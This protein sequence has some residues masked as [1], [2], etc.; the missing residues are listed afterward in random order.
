MQSEIKESL[1]RHQIQGRSKHCANGETVL[2]INTQS[3]VNS[4]ERLFHASSPVWYIQTSA[5]KSADCP[6]C[7]A[8]R[9][10]T[11]PSFLFPLSQSVQP[12]QLPFQGLKSCS[13]L[14]TLKKPAQITSCA[15]S[16]TQN[17]GLLNPSSRVSPKFG[18][19]SPGPTRFGALALATIVI[20]L[21]IH[22]LAQRVA[23][24]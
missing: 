14:N 17:H 23:A 15:S 2:P 16:A 18:N 4:H 3:F 21:P 10:R 1:M 9:K 24:T 5:G 13:F 19:R 22:W 7:N 6:S 11:R 8:C 12:N 20:A